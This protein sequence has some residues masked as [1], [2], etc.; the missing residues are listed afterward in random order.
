MEVLAI[1]PGPTKSA[2]IILSSGQIT[3]KGI[4]NNHELVQNMTYGT[5]P[6]LSY[7]N[8]C[9]IEMIASYG[10][11]V[12]AEVFETCVWIGRFTEA[13]YQKG[14][15]VEYVYR[16]QVKM[17]LCNSMKAKDGNIRQA[18][19]DKLGNCGTK[20]QPGPLYGVSKDIWSAL[21]VA[22]TFTELKERRD[23]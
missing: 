22:V 1:D 6:P 4:T 12:G 15:T 3:L 11:P 7:L 9:A 19:I 13:L 20:K 8:Y 14:I 16:K 21:A 5:W 18:L 2:W 17:H 23:V 10:M